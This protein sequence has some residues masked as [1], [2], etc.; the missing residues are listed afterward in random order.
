MIDRPTLIKRPVLE[1]EHFMAVGFSEKRFG[2]F[3][4]NL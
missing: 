4:K 2:E 1:A 3:I